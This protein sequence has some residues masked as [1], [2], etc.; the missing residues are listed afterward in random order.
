LRGRQVVADEQIGINY[1]GTDNALQGC[2]NDVHNVQRF[3]CG[4]S[5]YSSSCWTDAWTRVKADGAERF[6][7]DPSDIVILTDDS[8]NERQLP[9]RENI[10]RAMG[11]LVD[12]AGRDDAL[13]FH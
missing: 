8:P 12:G 11:W 2:I 4:V 6:G 1:I 9:T 3:I 7:Y 10:I 13:F 5:T